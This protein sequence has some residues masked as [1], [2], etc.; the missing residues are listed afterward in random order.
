MGGLVRT[1]SDWFCISI[2]LVCLTS[3][4]LL[5]RGWFGRAIAAAV[6]DFS[7]NPEGAW[8]GRFFVRLSVPR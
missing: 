5:P 1:R 4:H 7:Q 3:F 2:V 6:P 8:R